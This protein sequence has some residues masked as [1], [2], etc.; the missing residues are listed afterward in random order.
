MTFWTFIG[1]H[2][3]EVLFSLITTF[4]L[5]LCRKIWADKEKYEKIMNENKDQI[6]AKTISEQLDEKLEPIINNIEI[7]KSDFVFL[8]EEINKISQKE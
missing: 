8:R 1:E 6:L 7:L 2:F 5:Y 4:L 3:I